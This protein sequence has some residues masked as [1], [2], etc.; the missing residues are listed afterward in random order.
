MFFMG[1]NTYIVPDLGC[2]TCM[3]PDG[4]SRRQALTRK[5]YFI[6]VWTELLEMDKSEFNTAF[7]FSPG[8][9]NGPNANLLTIPKQRS[10]SVTLTYHAGPRRTGEPPGDGYP[11]GGVFLFCPYTL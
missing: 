7:F 9:S 1:T 6:F 5:L 11:S 2:S 10:S 3:S 8:L 4:G